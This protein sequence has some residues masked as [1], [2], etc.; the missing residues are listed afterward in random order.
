MSTSPPLPRPPASAQCRSGPF[1]LLVL[2]VQIRGTS[3]MPQEIETD[4]EC[5]N[6]VAQ[7]YIYDLEIG[8]HQLRI[9]PV[10]R[11]EISL[12][13]AEEHDHGHNDH[14]HF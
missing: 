11:R 12:V 4:G 2:D 1:L 8:T 5:P 7:V 14:S 13:F 10:T 3:L 9:G 6:V